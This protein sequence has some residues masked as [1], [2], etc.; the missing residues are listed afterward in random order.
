MI[1]RY[2]DEHRDDFGVAP[3]CT[4]LQVAPSTYYSAKSRK[5]SARSLRDA[6][7]KIALLAL[8]TANYEVYGARK[9]WKAATRTGQI[10]GRDQVARIMREL[11]IRGVRRGG[12]VFTTRPDVTAARAP[13]LVDRQFNAIRPNALWVTDLTYVATWAGTVYVC[14]IG[15]AFSRMIVGWR[16]ATNMRTDMVLDSLEMARWSRG[17]RLE[18]LVCHSDAG[19]QFTSIRYGERLAEIGALP[20]I[21]S[22]GDSFDNALAET[23]NGL[24][25]TELIRRRGPWRNVDEVELATLEWVHW[26]NTSRLHSTL[27]DV[28]PAEFEAAYYR[29]LKTTEPVGIQ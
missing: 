21:G 12:K 28:P 5:P 24:Y 27:D 8:W 3:I 13:D 11:G 18:G 23:V 2:I 17:T 26:F 7:L 19:S 1:V 29:R 4:T 6:V 16:V 20:S 14:F 10:V 15:D 25:K 22:V 9:L